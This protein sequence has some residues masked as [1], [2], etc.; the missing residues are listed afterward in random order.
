MK[1]FC[2]LR[3]I[4]VVSVE[5]YGINSNGETYVKKCLENTIRLSESG[6]FVEMFSEFVNA[7]LSL[8]IRDA[9]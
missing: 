2:L 7:C 5:I 3:G 1:L 4:S 6:F 9:T 8:N